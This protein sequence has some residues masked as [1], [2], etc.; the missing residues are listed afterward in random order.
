MTLNFPA[1]KKSDPLTKSEIMKLFGGRFRG[2]YVFLVVDLGPASLHGIYTVKVRNQ[3]RSQK[4]PAHPEGYLLL[5]SHLF[6]NPKLF[7]HDIASGRCCL[8]TPDVLYNGMPYRHWR[9]FPSLL[10]QPQSDSEAAQLM[11]RDV[12]QTE[13][14]DLL[15]NTILKNPGDVDTIADLMADDVLKLKRDASRVEHSGRRIVRYLPYLD[16]VAADGLRAML[17]AKGPPSEPGGLV[18][19]SAA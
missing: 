9:S 16:A 14:R 17:L 19:A 13:T 5:K 4:S 11:Q 8:G 2:E 15:F 6:T 3:M 18:L 1:P 12:A 7:R 10:F